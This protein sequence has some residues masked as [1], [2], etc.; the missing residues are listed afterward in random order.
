MTKLELLDQTNKKNT[1]RQ[2]VAAIYIY[3]ER[4]SMFLFSLVELYVRMYLFRI[5][6]NRVLIH[7]VSYT[8]LNLV[9]NVC[10]RFE[11]KKFKIVRDVIDNKIYLKK[12]IL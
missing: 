11:Q 2:T 8:L 1:A 3:V 10:Y 12:W 7:G 4:C 6:S 5:I 9:L